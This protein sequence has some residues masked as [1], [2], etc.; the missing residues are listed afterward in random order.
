MQI[1]G[2]PRTLPAGDSKFII[3]NAGFEIRLYVPSCGI[4]IGWDGTSNVVISVPTFFSSGLD[5][6]CGNCNGDR[7]DDPT[8]VDVYSKYATMKGSNTR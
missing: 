2:Q 7:R 1:N 5:G 4:L 6:I 8:N 3:Y